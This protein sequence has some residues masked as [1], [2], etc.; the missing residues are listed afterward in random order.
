MTDKKEK[1]VFLKAPL[2]LEEI[3]KALPHRYPFLLLDRILEI[4]PMSAVGL[5]NVSGNEPFFQWHFPERPVMPGVLL[6][7]A[8][9]QVG[10]VMMLSK[11]EN[12]GKIAYLVSVD[13]A[14]FR[15]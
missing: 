9:A 10:G 4:G 14:R 1:E 6:I 3:K 11:N 15:K 12:K 5:K 8:L 13:K 2:G 7:E